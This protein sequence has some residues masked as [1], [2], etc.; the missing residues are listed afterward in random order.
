MSLTKKLGGVWIGEGCFQACQA[1]VGLW[2]G[3]AGSD[4]FVG[5]PCFP[6]TDVGPKRPILTFIWVSCTGA[7]I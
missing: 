3:K 2:H 7:L 5:E 6:Q 4:K 1:Q